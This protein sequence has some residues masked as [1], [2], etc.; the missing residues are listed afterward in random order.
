MSY[1]QRLANEHNSIAFGREELAYYAR[2]LLL[3]GIGLE[4][5]QKLKCARVLVVGAGG[6][7][8]PALQALAG[9][10]VGSICIMDGDAV[11]GSNLSR[12]WLHTYRTIG[13]NK[14]LSAQAALEAINPF[15]QVSAYP[16]MLDHSNAE[17]KIAGCDIVIDATDELEVRYLI[18]DYCAALDRPW[19]H[20]ALYRESAQM[21]VFWS[22]FGASF[23][24]LYPV[25]SVAPSCSASGLLGAS[26]SI[27]GN[28]QALEAIKLITGH[29]APEV[30]TLC[31]LKTGNYPFERFHFDGSP[32]TQYSSPVQ[33]SDS[34]PRAVSPIELKQ[35][36][37][38]HKPLTIL[39]LRKDSADRLPRAAHCSEASLLEGGL[40]NFE[41]DQIL[42]VCE[43]GLM[44]EMLAHALHGIEP[45]VH[46]LKGGM[47]AW[48]EL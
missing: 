25:P 5:Q 1:I 40:S 34:V 26:A 13:Q 43:E 14:A 9:S 10:G 33:D 19:V 29:G 22:R 28:L 39:D 11:A 23:R 12:Q 24:K 42:L 31:S 48:R 20:A 15:I 30:G 44:S 47:R 37:S 18:D 46:Y 8:C 38:I 7:G 6:L 16:E 45:R 27:V 41:T 2:H 21:T 36:L 17:Q 32:P 4:G 35:A 3:P